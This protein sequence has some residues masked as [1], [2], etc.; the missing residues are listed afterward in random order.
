MKLYIITFA[1]IL[2]GSA[3]TISQWHG[4]AKRNTAQALS[5]PTHCVYRDNGFLPDPKCTPGA[6]NHSVTQ[7]TINKT[8]CVVGWTA[9][10][11]PSV[12]VTEPIKFDLMKSYGD[13]L[14]ASNYEL[15][16]LIP[17]EL[18][19]S[20]DSIKNLWPEPHEGTNGSYKKDG[21]EN[22]LKAEVCSGAM[23]LRE[24]RRIMSKGLW[25]NGG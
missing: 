3:Y 16:H 22:K 8:I 23:K 24:A 12:S 19:G 7:Q 21:W 11:R 17:L 1:V 18:G 15:D 5:V 10:I 6:I 4:S 14:S 20:P 9:T 2:C 13:Q 25:V